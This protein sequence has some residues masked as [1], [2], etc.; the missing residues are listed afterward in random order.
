MFGKV[1]KIENQEKNLI[2]EM[3]VFSLGFLLIIFQNL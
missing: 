3:K 2:K 1:P